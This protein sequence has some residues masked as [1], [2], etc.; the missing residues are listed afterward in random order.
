VDTPT[1]LTGLT[2]L[3]TREHVGGFKL[4]ESI[5]EPCVRCDFA[6]PSS[7]VCE[8][9]AA[10]RIRGSTSEVS[11]MLLCHDILPTAHTLS[12]LRRTVRGH[13][14]AGHVR[15]CRGRGGGARCS[16]GCDQTRTWCP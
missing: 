12:A 16:T 6:N 15:V 10:I 3:H 2:H 7:D 5:P 4:V 9:E 1:V 11:E 13:S 14:A 8:M